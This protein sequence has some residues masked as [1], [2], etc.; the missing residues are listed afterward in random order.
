MAE[1]ALGMAM[2]RGIEVRLPGVLHHR[3]NCLTGAPPVPAK[4]SFEA[5]SSSAAA[6][7]KKAVHASA[8][9]GARQQGEVAL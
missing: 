1:V 3:E 4:V 6:A 9:H 8:L 7:A 2:C 5:F